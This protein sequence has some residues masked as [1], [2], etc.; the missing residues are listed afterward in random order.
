MIFSK[1]VIWLG[2]RKKLVSPEIE[3]TPTCF[4]DF[5]LDHIRKTRAQEHGGDEFAH[6][7]R[8]FDQ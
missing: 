4:V 3:S 1:V 6:A 5:A 7:L 8:V 2:W